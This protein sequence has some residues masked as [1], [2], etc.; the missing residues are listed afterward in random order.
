[1]HMNPALNGS[2]ALRCFKHSNTIEIC[3]RFHFRF[4]CRTAADT[5]TLD[6]LEDMTHIG[7]SP[8][9]KSKIIPSCISITSL[10]LKRHIAE[11]PLRAGL[12]HAS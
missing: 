1:M 5:C 12:I 11:F 10:C 4:V 9:Y 3:N 6:G 7:G 2:S 8:V